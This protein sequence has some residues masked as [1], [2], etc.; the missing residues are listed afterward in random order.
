MNFINK[1]WNKVKQSKWL[2]YGIGAAVIGFGGAAAYDLVDDRDVYA[3]GGIVKSITQAE[4]AVSKQEAA[5]IAGKERNTMVEEVEQEYNE[6]GDSVYQVEFADDQEDIYVDAEKGT[7]ITKDMLAEKIKVTEEKAKE[8]ALKEVSGV[9]TEFELDEDNAQF[10]YE[11]EVTS[12][13]G[14]ETEMT[15][16]AETGKILTKEQDRF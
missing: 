13:N 2:K 14:T 1:A 5:D 9:I 11:L 15:I 3:N 8:I 16:S 12:Q 4:P 10:V 6:N 7:V